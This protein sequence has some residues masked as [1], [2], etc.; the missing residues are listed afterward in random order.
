L[1]SQTRMSFLLKFF[2]KSFYPYKFGVV[3]LE[4]QKTR[5]LCFW[6]IIWE[7]STLP[8]SERNPDAKS[9]IFGELW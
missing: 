8:R 9:M 7:E 5:L 2:L 4:E 1:K 6:R 3:N